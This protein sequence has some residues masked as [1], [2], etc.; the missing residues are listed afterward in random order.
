MDKE[1][2]D[3]ELGKTKPTISRIAL[4]QLTQTPL[5]IALGVQVFVFFVVSL[6][7]LRYSSFVSF[8]L[9]AV[10]GLSTGIIATYWLPDDP[11]KPEG[12]EKQPSSQS[13]FQRLKDRFLSKPGELGL[14]TK[15]MSE[16]QIRYAISKNRRKKGV[17]GLFSGLRHPNLSRGRK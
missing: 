13:T 10:G 8:W 16:R 14:N 12:G 15:T 1:L 2:K 17:L 4:Q 7:M 9:A 11:N 3:S 5:P 6:L